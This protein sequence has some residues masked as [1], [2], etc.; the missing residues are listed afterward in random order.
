MKRFSSNLLLVARSWARCSACAVG[1]A[2]AYTDLTTVLDRSAFRYLKVRRGKVARSQHIYVVIVLTVTRV[3]AEGFP[4]GTL[5]KRSSPPTGSSGVHR[6]IGGKRR[7]KRLA[8][9][10][11][12]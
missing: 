8:R 10:G 12:A 9:R 1:A 4:Q 11:R 6:P 2:C 7:T 5:R 3:G